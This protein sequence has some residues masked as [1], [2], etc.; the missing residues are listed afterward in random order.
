MNGKEMYKAWA[1]DTG[2]TPWTRF[3]KPA[4]F[5]RA[6]EFALPKTIIQI[7]N[8]PAE[9][10][11][12][13]AGGTAVIVDL[14]GAA[15]VENGLALAQSGMRPV[16]LYNGIHETKIGGMPPAVDNA[17]IID[18]LEAGVPVLCSAYI[19]PGAPPAFLL[20][21]NRENEMPNA[22]HMYDNRWS[23]DFEDMPEAAY[24]T[25]AGINRIILWTNG[26]VRSD[27]HPVLDSYRDAGMEILMYRDGVV[28]TIGHH[29][30]G[31]A[32]AAQTE[33]TKALQE[34][35]RMFENARFGLLLITILAFVNLFFM[36]VVIEEPILWTA[37]SIMWLT[38]L[39]V[40][41]FVGDAI[42]VVM[43]GAYL[44]LY[45]LSQ[46]RRHLITSALVLFAI[47]SVIFYVYALYCGLGEFAGGSFW[48]G[49]VVFGLPIVFLVMLVKGRR[50]AEGLAALSTDE[51]YT[52][53]DRLDDSYYAPGH[54]PMVRRRRHFRG[55]RGYGGY[56]GSGRGGYHGGGYRGGYGGGFG[57][58]FGG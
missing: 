4:L 45:L 7:P 11:I 44:A 41:E 15:S 26:T 9:I 30:S 18:A 56:G 17:P 40:P 19:P 55:F 29:D 20:D 23:L 49:V 10:A 24:M 38:Y 53:L 36:F 3:A 2:T 14:P 28:S 58:G 32:P 27:L 47:D 52:S 1:P 6:D 25:D 21:Y 35:V 12:R 50:A 5:V 33:E 48:Y 22:Q 57:G 46:R 43:C 13:Q 37:P 8:V 16:P 54:I 39:W 34:N 51:Y 31:E 42:A